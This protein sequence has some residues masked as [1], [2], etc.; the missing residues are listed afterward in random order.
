MIVNYVDDLANIRDYNDNDWS[1]NGHNGTDIALHDF[2]NMDRFY[3]VRAAASGTV[4]E[5][6]VN[7]FD[8]NTGLDNGIPSNTVLIRHNDRNLCILFSYDE[9]ISNGKI[10]GIYLTRSDF[11]ICGQFWKFYGRSSSL[12]PDI[13]QMETGLKEILGREFI[14]NC[15]LYGR[16]SMLMLV[17][18]ISFF[19]IW[20]SIQKG[21]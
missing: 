14:I 4:V 2:R 16:A 5:L 7:N 19:M 6:T 20:E 11:R 13:F 1:Y 21:W 10:R 8:R 9:K 15:H 12:R 17:S 18:E 3:A